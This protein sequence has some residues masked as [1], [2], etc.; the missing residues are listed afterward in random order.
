M[1]DHEGSDKLFYA[2]ADSNPDDADYAIFGVAFEKTVSH[3]KGT[4]LAPHTIREESY[5]FETYHFRQNFDVRDVNICD[6]GTSTPSD[7]DELSKDISRYIGEIFEAGA[8]PIA[9]GGEHSISPFIV[10]ELVSNIPKNKLGGTL[11]VI[12]IDAHLDFRE[13]YLGE[14]NSHASAIRNIAGIVGVDSVLPVGVR[15]FDRDEHRDACEMGLRWIDS[16]GFLENRRGECLA[17]IRK[18]IGDH[19]VYLTIDMDGID[20]AYAPG[21]GTPEPFGLTPL[22]VLSIIETVSH[23]LIGLDVVEVCPTYDNGNTSALA[24]TLIGKTIACR[25]TSRRDKIRQGS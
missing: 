19:P 15:S 6:L 22:D 20:P 16:F 14:K 24:S 7:F 4:S 5:N 3:R 13:S 12:S 1:S 23:R 11:R 2:D 8:F 18:F 25:E 21:V 9:L 17:G 10:G